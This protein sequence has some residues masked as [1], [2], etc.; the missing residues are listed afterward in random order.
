M[1]PGSLLHPCVEYSLVSASGQHSLSSRRIGAA[2]IFA[3]RLGPPD[4]FGSDAGNDG[5]PCRGIEVR[6]ATTS[7][8]THFLGAWTIS[9]RAPDNRFYSVNCYPGLVGNFEFH[10]SRS[11][12]HLSFDSSKEFP[13][14]IAKLTGPS[15]DIA[16]VSRT[17]HVFA[18]RNCLAENE[19]RLREIPPGTACSGWPSFRRAYR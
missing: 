6:S 7:R 9:L 14:M 12:L 1:F 17:D 13:R 5:R 3:A 2:S 16:F 4:R 19:A 15:S 10:G 18:A 11:A 8:L